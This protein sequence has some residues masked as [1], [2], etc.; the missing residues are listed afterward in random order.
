MTAQVIE[1]KRQPSLWTVKFGKRIK[2]AFVGANARAQAEAYAAENHGAF[3]VLERPM[4]GKEQKR[5]KFLA[6]D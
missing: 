5:A 3:G 1:A 4:T 2:A 6:A